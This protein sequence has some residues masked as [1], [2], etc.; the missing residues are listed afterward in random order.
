MKKD[1]SYFDKNY[2]IAPLKKYK[3]RNLFIINILN[4]IN[5]LKKIFFYKNIFSKLNLPYVVLDEY[6]TIKDILAIY[7]NSLSN[8]TKIL[9]FFYKKEN[10]KIFFINGTNCRNIL[11]PHLL[12]SFCGTAQE[13]I[14]RAKSKYNFLKDNNKK[15]FI[16]YGEF[17]PGYLASY[18]FCKK[19]KSEN[20]Y[21]FNTT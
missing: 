10:K 21:N 13:F 15:I 16:C 7:L 11:L 5:F 8:F 17:N 6:I 4:K 3:N 19:S 18:H 1:G 9:L 2:L 20:A 14:L 12:N